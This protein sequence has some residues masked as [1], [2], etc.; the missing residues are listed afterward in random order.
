MKI[1]LSYN[2]YKRIITDCFKH[3]LTN[4]KVQLLL[5]DELNKYI[6]F[7]RIEVCIFFV[8]TLTDRYTEN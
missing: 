6:Y 2:L 4:G 1:Y 8:K 3:H 7:I 5:Y